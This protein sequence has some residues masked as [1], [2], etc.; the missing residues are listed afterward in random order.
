MEANNT[1]DHI[2]ATAADLIWSGGYNRTSVD[3][4]IR[5]ADVSKGSFYHHFSSKESLG[6]AVIDAWTAHFGAHIAAN[7]S[8][9]GC[10]EENLHAILDAMVSAQEESGFRGCPL[11]RLALEMGDV[12]ESFR[13]RLQ[14]GFNDLSDLF[15]TYLEQAGIP[16]PEAKARGDCMLATLEGALML[17]KVNGGGR[18][19]RA[20]IAT[21]K[22]DVSLK[23]AETAVWPAVGTV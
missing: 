11:G 10:P 13:Q 4:I 16:E 15:T 23:L 8:D 17:E 9:A 18:V 12:S 5:K 20:L 1:C 2:V 22:S 7:L 21:M 14:K 3:E 19:L 6:L